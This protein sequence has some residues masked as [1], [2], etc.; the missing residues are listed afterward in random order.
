MTGGSA[1]QRKVLQGNSA[2]GDWRVFEC[3]SS[4]REGEG[5]LRNAASVVG[6]C[7]QWASLGHQSWMHPPSVGS[8]RQNFILQ[9]PN[10]CHRFVT[11][12]GF[13][14]SKGTSSGLTKLRPIDSIFPK[15]NISPH[16]P[17]FCR[18]RDEHVLKG[19]LIFFIF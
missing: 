11:K 6:N 13:S 1:H 7:P 4:R 3:T 2:G 15:I 19:E 18:N 17:I 8:S 10:P 5:G 12:E 16:R 14:F 9:E